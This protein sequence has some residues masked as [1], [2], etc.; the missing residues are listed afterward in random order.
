MNSKFTKEV[1]SEVLGAAKRQPQ[2]DFVKDDLV[3][4]SSH[5]RILK[6]LK[7][8]G[9]DHAVVIDKHQEVI[10]EIEFPLSEIIAY[11]AVYFEAKEASGEEVIIITKSTDKN[12]K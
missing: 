8:N 1:F 12:N 2:K 4:H 3:C 7:M 6:F 9:G 10:T 11:E 5:P